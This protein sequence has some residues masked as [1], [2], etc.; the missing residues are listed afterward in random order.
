MSGRSIY[1]LCC[2]ARKISS[3]RRFGSYGMHLPKTRRGDFDKSQ[4]F[5]ETAAELIHDFASCLRM[6][7]E[8]WQSRE[9]LGQI[10]K[11]FYGFV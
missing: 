9:N 1:L 2:T 10:A 11:R 8:G 6:G 7:L 4:H 5:H 3:S